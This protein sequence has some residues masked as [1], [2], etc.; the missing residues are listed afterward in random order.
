MHEK[1]MVMD[2]ILANITWQ[3]NKEGKV[4]FAELKKKVKEKNK[5]SNRPAEDQRYSEEEIHN[6]SLLDANQG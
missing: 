1:K 3:N 4:T 6:S 2:T 5:K